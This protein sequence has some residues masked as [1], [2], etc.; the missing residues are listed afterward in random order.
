APAIGGAESGTLH[1]EGEGWRIDFEGRTVHVRDGKG[2]RHLALL[3]S[4]PG[5]EIHAVDIVTAAEGGGETHAMAAA[6]DAGLEVRAAVV[7][8][9]SGSGGA[10][11]SHVFAGRERVPVPGRGRPYPPG[12]F[13]RSPR[14][15]GGD[16]CWAPQR[17]RHGLWE[18][19]ACDKINAVVSS[20]LGGGSLI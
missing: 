6:A 15:V 18:L 8:V 16:A 1:R 14:R 5:V 10:M 7:A 3:L 17:E 9:G 11:V 4:R 19:L 2:M 13:P 20:G 12:S